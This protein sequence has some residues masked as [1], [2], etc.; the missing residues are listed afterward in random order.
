MPTMEALHPTSSTVAREEIPLAEILS[1]DT[2][3]TV[4]FR[5][6]ER[7]FARLSSYATGGSVNISEL[8]LETQFEPKSHRQKLQSLLSRCLKL[9]VLELW[10]SENEFRDTVD[11]VKEFFHDHPSFAAFR[12]TSPHFKATFGRKYFGNKI[13]VVALLKGARNP[14]QSVELTVFRRFGSLIHTVVIDETT[15]SELVVLLRDTDRR[16]AIS[17]RRVDVALASCDTQSMAA[18]FLL[19]SHRQ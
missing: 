1:S 18:P 5:R 6:I 16:Q 4:S 3:Q 10:C 11:L 9:K 7:Y 19:H 17:L 13:S 12:L 2:L 8:H 14:W 15:T